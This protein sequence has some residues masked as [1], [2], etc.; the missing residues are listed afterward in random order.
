MKKKFVLFLAVFGLLLST[1]NL[2][3]VKADTTELGF[4]GIGGNRPNQETGKAIFQGLI[5]LNVTSNID[6]YKPIE[7]VTVKVYDDIGSRVIADYADETPIY[8]GNTVPV[9]EFNPEATLGVDKYRNFKVEIEGFVGED[10]DLFFVASKEGYESV[11]SQGFIFPVNNYSV[12][13]TDGVDEEV[14]PDQVVSGLLLNTKTPAFSGTPTRE[15]YTFKGWDPEISELVTSNAVYEATWEKVEEPEVNTFKVDFV[16]NGGSEVPS[17]DKVEENSLI[18]KPKDPTR[19]GY[20][21]AGWYLD[22][23]SFEIRWEFDKHLVIQDIVLYAKWDEVG[24]GKEEETTSKPTNPITKETEKTKK[25][26]P[27]T[28]ISNMSVYLGMALL[29]TGGLSLYDFKRKSN[30]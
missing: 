7:D 12:T 24:G 5:G 19:E 29:G 30:K 14:F 6:N 8:V 25:S 1:V 18:T 9:Y 28:G 16:S 3:T 15:G 11:G 26:L 2:N 4:R 27:K 22:D 20:T 21:F 23:K 13:Y 17:I 10:R